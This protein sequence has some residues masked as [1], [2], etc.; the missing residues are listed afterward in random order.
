MVF[1]AEFCFAHSSNEFI[2]TK[3]LI[4]LGALDYD[5]LELL[6]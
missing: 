3:L 1:T 5:L 2:S 4:E 6:I